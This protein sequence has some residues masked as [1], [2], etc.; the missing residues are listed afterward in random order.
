MCV[1]PLD[2]TW[3]D[4]EHLSGGEKTLSSL[5]F[6]FALHEYRPTPFYI[7]DEIDAA[8]DFRNVG[9]VA[10][11]L[12][13]R[14]ESSQFIIISLRQ[15]LFTIAHQLVGVSKVKGVSSSLS[16]VSEV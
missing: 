15:E 4:L 16:L 7:F 9:I 14:S 6:L 5:A 2:K 3:R 11:F 1:R 12:Q 13:S 10:K 8:L